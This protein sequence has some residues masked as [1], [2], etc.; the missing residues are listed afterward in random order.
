MLD[1]LPFPEADNVR[2]RYMLGPSLLVAPVFVVAEEETEYYIPA[3]RWTSFFH[4]ERTV[5]GP[6]WIKEIVRLALLLEK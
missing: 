6:L 3:G 5:Q 1:P 4:P 2:S